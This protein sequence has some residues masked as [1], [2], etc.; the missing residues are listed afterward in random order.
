MGVNIDVLDTQSLYKNVIKFAGSNKLHQV[1]YVN[2]DCMLIAWKDY[3][4]R[5]ILNSAHLVYADGKSIVWGAR[6]LGRYL[7]NR[8]TGADFMPWFSEGFA[9]KGFRIFLLG[10]RPGIAAIAGQRLKLAIP[11]LQIVGVHHGYFNDYENDTVF[12]L[13]KRAKPHILLV[14]FGAPKQEKWIAKN[15]QF[16]EV[17][18]I[19]GVGGLF[20]FIS[21]RLKRGP[22]ILLNNGFEWLCR[23]FVEPRRLWKR[24]LLGNVLFMGHVLK[25][26]CFGQKKK[27]GVYGHN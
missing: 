13:I 7:P 2:A 9:D 21:G 23:L 8:S 24:Y 12:D 14:G 22:Q 5:K 10:A 20:D 18:V 25:W 15:Y 26:K 19:W 1:M 3:E 16:L 17:P 27:D 6:I 4:Y 11:K